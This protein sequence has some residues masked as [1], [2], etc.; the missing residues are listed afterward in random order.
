MLPIR[1]ILIF[2]AT[3]LAISCDFAHAIDLYVL[4]GNQMRKDMGVMRMTIRKMPLIRKLDF[5]GL[6]LG[7]GNLKDGYICNH[8]EE[9]FPMGILGP[10]YH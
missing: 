7:S 3:T 1:I 2:F 8:R 10:K 4:G 6:L 9:F 5:T